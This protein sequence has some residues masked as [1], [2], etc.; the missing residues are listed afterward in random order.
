MTW[1]GRTYFCE[2]HSRGWQTPKDCEVPLRSAR[3][4]LRCTGHQP[5]KVA[6]VSQIAAPQGRR[7]PV[8]ICA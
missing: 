7:G 6:T 5:S 4:L 1:H 8:Q 2:R 3:C